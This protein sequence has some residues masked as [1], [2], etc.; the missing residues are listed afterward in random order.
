MSFA[1]SLTV[2]AERALD[3]MPAHVRAPILRRIRALAENPRPSGIV[4]LKGHAGGNYRLRVGDYRVAYEGVEEAR[5]VIVW[6]IG[7]RRRFY[8]E[9][10]RRRT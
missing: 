4:A 10:K 2:R 7:N 6:E 9:T 1:V 3:D 5:A 8:E